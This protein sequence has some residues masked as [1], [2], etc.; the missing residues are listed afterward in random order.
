[1]QQLKRMGVG[2]ASEEDQGHSGMYV[3]NAH[4]YSFPNA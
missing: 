2:S 4:N 3:A 1:M